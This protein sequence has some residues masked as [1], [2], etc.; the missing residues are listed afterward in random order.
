[1]R[2]G[3][4]DSVG[5]PPSGTPPAP[6]VLP[7]TPQATPHAAAAG[8]ADAFMAFAGTDPFRGPDPFAAVDPSIDPFAS[9]SESAMPVRRWD[10][11][12]F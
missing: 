10:A 11:F 9:G 5:E 4:P 3:S 6:P 8:D 7:A 2:W 1:M 12:D